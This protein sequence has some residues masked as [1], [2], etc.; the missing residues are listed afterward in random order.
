MNHRK[1]KLLHNEIDMHAW[2]GIH[3]ESVDKVA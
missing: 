2:Q 3:A 1:G